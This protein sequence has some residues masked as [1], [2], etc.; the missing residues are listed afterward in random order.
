MYIV[1]VLSPL[2][3]LSK[4]STAQYSLNL[5]SSTA[6]KGLNVWVAK[7]T[8]LEKFYTAPKKMGLLEHF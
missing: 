1:N 8:A 7:D 2:R 4:P 5:T 3:I 6:R